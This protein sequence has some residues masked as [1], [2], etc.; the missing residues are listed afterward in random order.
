MWL[1]LTNKWARLMRRWALGAGALLLALSSS[2]ASGAQVFDIGLSGSGTRIDA[3]VA[4]SHIRKSPVVVLVGGLAGEDASSAAVRTALT[5]LERRHPGFTLLAVPVANPDR[6][7]LQFPPVGVAYRDNPESHVLWRWLGAQAPDLVLVAGQDAGLLAALGSGDVALMGPL[8]ARAWSGIAEELPSP[9]QIKTSAARQ[10]L[11]RRQARTPRQLARQLAQHYGRSFDQPW[12]IDAV[13]LLARLRLGD[14]DEVQQLASTW[15]DG[16]KDPWAR[17]SALTMAGH[18]VFSQLYRQTRDPRY[19]AAVRRVADTGFDAR[20]QMLDA[21]PL[22]GEYSDSVFMGTV[23]AAQAGALTGE[24]RYFEMADRHLRFMERLDRRPDGLY[25]HQPATDAAWGRGNGFAALGL[26]LTLSELPRD[27]AAYRHALDSYR[28]LMNAL[29]PLQ[30]RD[31][32]WR[33]VV[34]HP[35]AYPEFSATAMIGFA[36]RRGIARGW[37]KGSA[38]R[39]AVAQAWNAVNT[40][41][42]SSGTFIDV[43]E[44]TTRMTSLDQ[45]LKRAAILG[46]DPRGGAM[47][48]LFATELMGR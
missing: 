12:Y 40:R 47:A 16:T 19:L 4:N 11:Q 26:A 41:T 20:G 35:G 17:P 2:G 28:A 6:A 29:L 7:A 34:D 8:E 21:M 5:R 46:E 31:G 1:S 23:I 13:A 38:Y 10:E 3:M 33:N 18:I 48:M 14:L 42:S 22:H 9:R 36:L 32:L 45:Y 27:S 39:R 44:S 30:N 15:V 25:R 24:R 43:C 37:I